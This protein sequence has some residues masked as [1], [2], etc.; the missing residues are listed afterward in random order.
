MTAHLRANLWLLAL[1]ALLCSVLY[2][3]VLLGIGQTVFRDKAQGSLLT[4]AKANPLG[5]RLIAQPFT[6]DEYFQPRPSAASY[7]A[8]ASGASNWGA[9]NYLLRDRVANQLGP[10]VKY[11]SGPKKGQPVG[12]DIET[13][14]QKDQ[15]DGKPGI[16]AQWAALHSAV[17]QNWVKGDKLKSA[18]VADWQKAHPAEVADWIRTN[19]GTPDPKPED[20]AVPFFTD[21]SKSYPGTFLIAVEH[22]TPD[23]KTEKK[24]EP[25]KEGTN[26][27]AAYFD[28]WLQE[29]NDAD[30]EHVPADMVM[31]SGS[32]LDP[33]ITLSNA[34]WQL[35]RV[36]A[37]W[38]KKN[39]ADETSLHREIEQL[40]RDKSYSPL[41]GLF[42]VPLVN[43][44]EVNL[45]LRDRYQKTVR[46]V[47]W[48]AGSLVNGSEQ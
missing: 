45:D 2:P 48:L 28:M 46:G 44:L 33:N 9:S 26:I 3:L 15:F 17:A 7:N 24:I 19:P 20:L 27:Q 29:H 8:A 10:T 11:R 18:Y 1:T 42:G 40:L 21:F 6:A 5:S 14:F 22:K 16:V 25:V 32:G 34:L 13:W 35:D 47:N 38:A 12:P 23:G 4:D 36:A 37:A 41:G 31:A 43:V 39:G 30:L